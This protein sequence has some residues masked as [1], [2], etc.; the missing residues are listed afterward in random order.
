MTTATP[1]R[2]RVHAHVEN[3]WNASDS[4]VDC[5]LSVYQPS[6]QAERCIQKHMREVI[7]HTGQ[8]S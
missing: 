7:S 2:I 3:V 5:R 8:N 6:D 1:T 4:S